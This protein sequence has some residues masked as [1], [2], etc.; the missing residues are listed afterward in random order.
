ML[1]VGV[2]N[3]G[4]GKN[5]SA[6]DTVFEKYAL[7]YNTLQQTTL[8]RLHKETMQKI[9]QLS[10]WGAENIKGRGLQNLSLM[11]RQRP[12]VWLKKF[13]QMRDTIFERLPNKIGV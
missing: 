10:F 5:F 7:T 9:D 13:Y 12:R 8:P 6:V 2:K 3:E 11:E 1:S 4:P